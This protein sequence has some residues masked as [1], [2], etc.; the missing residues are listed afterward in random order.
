[1]AFTQQLSLINL[2]VGTIVFGSICHGQ[3]KDNQG[4]HFRQVFRSYMHAPLAN[5]K[6]EIL[7]NDGQV[8]CST[9]ASGFF[10]CYLEGDSMQVDRIRIAGN[11][12][13]VEIKQDYP[14]SFH[15]TDSSLEAISDIDDTAIVSYTASTIKRIREIFKRPSKRLPIEFTRQILN[16]VATKGKVYYVSKSEVNLFPFLSSILL[17][18]KFPIGPMFMTGMLK[19][20][21]LLKPHKDP[22]H[23]RKSI[24][25]I[26]GGNP[27]KKYVL[28][29]DDT[30][31]DMQ[32]YR[33]IASKYLD[34][35]AKIYIRNTGVR[36]TRKQNETIK[37]LQDS[38]FDFLYF[39]VEDDYNEEIDLLKTYQK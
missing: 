20:Y 27:T 36:L 15:Y 21:Q 5:E 32:I 30:Q 26:I 22:L 37:K 14:V 2:D 23:K 19:G 35:V 11:K 24:E 13:F 9:D 25:R 29:G 4:S 16:A 10:F 7:C 1:M 6:I 8:N 34:Q 33:E 18:S 12:E 3:L 28:I 31:L 17:K 39:N 38:K